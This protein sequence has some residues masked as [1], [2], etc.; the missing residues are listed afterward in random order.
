MFI[1][2]GGKSDY[3]TDYVSG[4]SAAA[5]SGGITWTDPTNALSDDG[6]EAGYTD[7]KSN[8]D[9]KELYIYNFGFN[10]P[11]DATIL[12]YIP[13]VR[14]RATSDPTRISSIYGTAGHYSGG[15]FTAL[16]GGSA[17]SSGIIAGTDITTETEFLLDTFGTQTVTASD[18]NAST[19][20]IA[21]QVLTTSLI[22]S[23][24]LLID[25]VS[26]K[27]TYNG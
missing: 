3:D 1:C 9:T 19:F 17:A 13:K 6:T 15:V 11:G 21:I 26:L 5:E 22:Y 27:L 7:P 14:I 4:G 2:T 10:V 18:V 16:S 25:Y 20:C 8:V 24:N 23:P 12:S